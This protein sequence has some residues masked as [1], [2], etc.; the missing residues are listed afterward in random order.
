MLLLL[1]ANKPVLNCLHHLITLIFSG[2]LLK[3]MLL[4]NS[5]LEGHIYLI[6]GLDCELDCWHGRRAKHSK[7]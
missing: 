1:Y 5:K 4:W 3:C 2:R 6:T 7:G